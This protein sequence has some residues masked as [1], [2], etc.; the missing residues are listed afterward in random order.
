MALPIIEKRGGIMMEN[1]NDY[2]SLL[3][4]LLIVISGIVGFTKLNHRLKKEEQN[5]EFYRELL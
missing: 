5:D 4:L 2:L 3:S 1:I